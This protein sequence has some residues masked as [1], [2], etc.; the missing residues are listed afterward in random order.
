MIA[1][2]TQRDDIPTKVR[3]DLAKICIDGA[4]ADRVTYFTVKPVSV[5]KRHELQ[6]HREN[7]SIALGIW[8]AQGIAEE[9]AASYDRFLSGCRLPASSMVTRA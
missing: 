9:L 6:K 8:D 7:R 5:S 2:T 1:A 4:P 3:T